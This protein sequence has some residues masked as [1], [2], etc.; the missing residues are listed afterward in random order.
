[1]PLKV[2]NGPAK[3][4][5]LRLDLRQHGQYWIGDYDAY[6]FDHIPWSR[7]LKAGDIAWDCG[8][9]VGYYT[10]VFR[11]HVGDSGHVA[12]F[13]ASA[14]NHAELVKLPPNNGWR[15][16][17]VHHAAVGADHTE[18]EFVANL[19]GASGPFG[20]SKQYAA[21]STLQIERVRC[22][23]IDELVFEKQVPAPHLMK[24]DLESAE[25]FALH[26]G[27]RVFNETRPV[28]LLELHGQEAAE[29]A[30]RF[31]EIYRYAGTPVENLLN[32]QEASEAAW[33]ESL[34][35]SAVRTAD[36][37]RALPYIPHMLLVLPA[38]HRDWNRTGA[39]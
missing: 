39:R 12:V 15:N 23:G 4:T 25:V 18:I 30:G 20:L 11:K 7:Y 22:H 9:Y 8:A 16:V 13:E 31:L 6:A 32:F 14:I 1:M 10:A 27:P 2:R 33:L 5:L 36:E 29:A 17:T 35:T 38:E 3:G 26:N 19:G 34:Q 21:S 28:I 24:L 37:L